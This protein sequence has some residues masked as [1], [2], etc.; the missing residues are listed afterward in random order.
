VDHYET[1]Q[2]SRAAEPEVIEKAYRALA[3]KYH[4]D[5]APDEDRSAATERFQGITEAYSVLSDPTRRAAYDRTLPDPGSRAWE[6]F[7]DEGLLGL[8]RDWSRAKRRS[9]SAP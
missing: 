8:Y 6:R 9:D 5:R 1:L 4:P 3:L 7:M 2:V